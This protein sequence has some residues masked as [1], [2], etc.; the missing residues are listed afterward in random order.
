MS[1]RTEYRDR[2]IEVIAE[3]DALLAAL[4]EL[5]A[6]VHGINAG[7]EGG[8]PMIN[9]RAAISKAKGE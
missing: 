8:E 7:Y 5:V 4:E 1:T 2:L 3:R 9:A 6:L